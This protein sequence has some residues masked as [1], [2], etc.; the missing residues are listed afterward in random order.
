MRIVVGVDGSQP[1]RVALELLRAV[2]WPPD[3]SVR[4]V[5]AALSRAQ[6][7]RA[8][9]E[10]IERAATDLRTARFATATSIVPGRPA[11]ALMA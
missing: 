6:D 11:D 3:T 2:D 8:Q 7:R 1:S 4:I 5:G 10:A 9:S